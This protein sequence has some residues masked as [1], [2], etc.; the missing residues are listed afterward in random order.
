M[1]KK[2]IF[3]IAAGLCLILS[4]LSACNA[5]GINKHVPIYKGMTVSKTSRAVPK[6]VLE[7]DGDTSNT[8]GNTET[9]ERKEHDDEIEKD[10]E[11]IITINVETDDSVKYYVKPS[12]TFIVEV[13]IDNPN[14][15]E[16]QSF[17]LNGNKYANYMFKEGSTMELLL[18][19]TTAPAESGYHEY[20]IDAIKY[21]DGTEIKDV[22]M[23][24]ANK[25]IKVGVSYI[26]SPTASVTKYNISSTSAEMT[27][28]VSDPQKN[29]RQST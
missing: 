25:T 17:T 18:L 16:I 23:S 12:E 22:D 8:T 5:P 20:T 10:I 11:N 21:I 1:K 7:D 4:S 6:S 13:H 15:F 27:I 14:D 24:S 26:K 2:N 29:R 3:E 9:D 28:D 19:E